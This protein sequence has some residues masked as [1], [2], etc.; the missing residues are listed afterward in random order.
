MEKQS[1]NYLLDVLNAMEDGVY[2]I[3][4]DYTV[5]FMNHAMVE[6]FGDGTGRKCYEVVN[7]S[8]EICPWCRTSSV[9]K[10][11]EI[12]HSEIHVP[13]V[14]RSF[15]VT[16]LPIRNR[17]GS[18]SE[19]TLYRDISD[20]KRKELRLKASEEDY[21]RLFRHQPGR[22]FRLRCISGAQGYSLFGDGSIGFSSGDHTQPV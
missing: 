6:I 7:R 12:I 9:F 20:E 14:A 17:D 4:S 18:I 19:M 10:D 5:E 16:D 21:R 11:G 2:I 15:R 3:R 1:N 22:H 13:C 8:S